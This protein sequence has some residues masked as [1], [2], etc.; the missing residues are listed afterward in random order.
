[1]TPRLFLGGPAH[2][3]ILDI[4]DDRSLVVFLTPLPRDIWERSRIAP[5]AR[6]ETVDYRS[7]PIRVGTSPA[8]I[9]FAHAALSDAA[10]ASMVW[11]RVARGTDGTEA[12]GG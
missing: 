2:G 9:I 12:G 5:D 7:V 1:M 4:G 3:Q 6:V 10:V 8:G 11:Y